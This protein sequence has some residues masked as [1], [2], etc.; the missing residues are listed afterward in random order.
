MITKELIKSE[1]EKVKDEY[2]ELLYRVVG[3]KLEDWEIY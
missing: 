3:L 1:I 2:L